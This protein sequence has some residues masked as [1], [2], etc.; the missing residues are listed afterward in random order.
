MIR[1]VDDE[2]LGDAIE[3]RPGL[4]ARSLLR[5]EI[6]S[7]ATN[8][9][10]I[11][12]VAAASLAVEAPASGTLRIDVIQFQGD[13]LDPHDAVP[14]NTVGCRASCAVAKNRRG[15]SC[16]CNIVALRPTRRQGGTSR[17]VAKKETVAEGGEHDR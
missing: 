5:D 3:G 13:S 4:S 15:R 11:P 2:S 7:E 6:Y 9:I 14:L 1:S 8:G 12:A 10:A 17:V 16:V